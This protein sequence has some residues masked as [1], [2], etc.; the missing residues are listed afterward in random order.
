MC[1]ANILEQDAISIRLFTTY[2]AN[3][4]EFG[5]KANTAIVV[6]DKDWRASA[7]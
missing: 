7:R 3:K 4:W 1:N 6:H 2:R 5:R